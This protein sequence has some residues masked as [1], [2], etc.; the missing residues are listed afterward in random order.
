MSSNVSMFLYRNVTNLGGIICVLLGY[1]NSFKGTVH[2]DK[3]GNSDIS[4]E[5]QFTFS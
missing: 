3:K 4:L 1:Y 2:T 5:H